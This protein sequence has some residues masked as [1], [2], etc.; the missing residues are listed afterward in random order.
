MWHISLS[1][2]LFTSNIGGVKKDYSGN[3]HAN[4]ENDTHLEQQKYH[5][6]NVEENFLPLENKKYII[7]K[8]SEINLFPLQNNLHRNY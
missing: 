6:I 3:S 8:H 5:M 7:F 4:Q 1:Q 2:N